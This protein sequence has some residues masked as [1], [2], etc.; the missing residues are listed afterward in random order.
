MMS[1]CGFSRRARMTSQVFSLM[2]GKSTSTACWYCSEPGIAAS[3][4]WCAEAYR[5]QSLTSSPSQSTVTRD[6]TPM[7]DVI[8]ASPDSMTWSTK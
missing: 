3:A 2:Y 4:A 6:G 8:S 5:R 1:S 7:T